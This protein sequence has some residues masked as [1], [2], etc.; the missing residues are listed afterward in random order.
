MTA[1][2][3]TKPTLTAIVFPPSNRRPIV[4][5]L[6]H[7]FPSPQDRLIHTIDLF[8]ASEL[9]A[10]V[11]G[12]LTHLLPDHYVLANI[13]L[14]LIFDFHRVKATLGP[15]L[16]EFLLLSSH[17]D[18][19]ISARGSD[20]SPFGL[21]LDG[22]HHTNPWNCRQHVRDKKKNLLFCRS[23]LPL[24]RVRPKVIFRRGEDQSIAAFEGDLRLLFQT[25][26][27]P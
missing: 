5:I 4:D 19:Y 16:A 8:H 18:F 6:D 2:T 25:I 13:D 14:H 7:S 22:P 3:Y 17:V 9:E 27:V 21:E 10:A 20:P 23:G 26:G 11:F 1:F 15:E 24:V 12:V